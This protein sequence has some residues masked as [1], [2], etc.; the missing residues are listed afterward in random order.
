M[1]DKNRDLKR[2]IE[3]ERLKNKKLTTMEPLEVEPEEWQAFRK[4]AQP[5]ENEHLELRAALR[6]TEAALRANPEN[7]NLKA[8]MKYLKKRLED[9]DKQAPWISSDSP[10]E[11]L[12]WGGT[13]GC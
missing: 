1:E 4:M 13:W 9:L 12:L 2:K 8:R 3:E 11:I 6:D 10:W 5:L 7:E